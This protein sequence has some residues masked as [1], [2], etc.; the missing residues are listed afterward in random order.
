[1]LQYAVKYNKRFG[2]HRGYCIFPSCLKWL[3]FFCWCSF[4]F[5]FSL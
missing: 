3:P 2:Q 4:S 5:S 1:L